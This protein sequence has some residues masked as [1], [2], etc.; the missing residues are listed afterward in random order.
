MPEFETNP[1]STAFDDERGV[2]RDHHDMRLQEQQLLAQQTQADLE[3]EQLGKYDPSRHGDIQNYHAAQDDITARQGFGNPYEGIPST[4]VGGREG[5]IPS[6]LGG[7]T[8]DDPLGNRDPFNEEMYESPRDAQFGGTVNAGLAAAR[9][10]STDIYPHLYDEAHGQ[11]FGDMAAPGAK[12]NKQAHE[13]ATQ[14]HSYI[15]EKY[16]NEVGQ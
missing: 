8:E 5:M 7:M 16:P 1:R 3:Y 11:L 2:S 13:L 10:G 4:R 6:W 15:N 9:G 12:R 14:A